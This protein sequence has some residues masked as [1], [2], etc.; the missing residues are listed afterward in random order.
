MELVLARPRGFCAG[1]V[2]AI[3]V[4]ES[5]LAAFGAPVYV[6]HEIV[7][8]ARVVEELKARGALFVNAL[9]DVPEGA[10]TIFSAH[11]V[12]ESVV[13]EA[14]RRQL[15]F[16]D[17][18][19]PLVSK[20][21]QEV[22]HHAREGREVV[23]IG[24]AGHAEVTGTLGRYDTSAGGAVYLVE[25]LA[26]VASLAVRDPT[27]LSYVTQT[28]LSLDDASRIVAALKAR[29]PAITGP[30]RDDICYATQNRQAAVRQ[31]AGQVDLLL[32][33]GARNSSNS[34]RLQEVG[35][36]MGIPSYLLQ[37]AEDLCP[38]W[39][40][41]VSRIGLTAG[42]STPE[43]LVQGVVE[44]LRTLGVS[45]VREMAAEVETITFRLPNPLGRKHREAL[46]A[47]GRQAQGGA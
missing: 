43:I 41:G 13:R 6:V 46:A 22:G 15:K 30:R 28:T 17:A 21:H 38:Q 29:Y 32:V 25:T 18:T 37:S 35:A 44:R 47:G 3:G 11:G 16:V 8:N 4:V 31:L 39:L 19:C 36:Q 33:V 24:H 9:K 42:A 27:R 1:V 7:H 20:V 34:N 10:V 26:D 23:L 40:E 2:R 45:L 12:P 5:A 14:Q